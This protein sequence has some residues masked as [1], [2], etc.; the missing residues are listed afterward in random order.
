MV[1]PVPKAEI[2]HVSM[3]YLTLEGET[4]ALQ[5]ICLSIAE[6][7]FVSIVGP[8]GCGKSTLLS[9][10]SGL[11]KPTRAGFLIDGVPLQGITHKLGYMLQQDYLFEWRTIYNNVILGWKSRK[12]TKVYTPAGRRPPAA[13]R[14]LGFRHHYPHQLGHA[15]AGSPDPT[16]P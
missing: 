6:G 2:D 7:E 12:K 16:L 8:S 14:A 9:L 5:D 1:S 11:L 13:L 4:E 15:P 10:I 3:K